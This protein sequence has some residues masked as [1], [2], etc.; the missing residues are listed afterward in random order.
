MTLCLQTASVFNTNRVSW[1]PVRPSEQ[2][3]QDTDKMLIRVSSVLE[4]SVNCLLLSSDNIACFNNDVCP[5]QSRLVER[6][7]GRGRCVEQH[8]A[9]CPGRDPR[10]I[11]LPGKRPLLGDSAERREHGGHLARPR[12]SG[13]EVPVY[14]PPLEPHKHD[15]ISEL[16]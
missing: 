3:L 15:Q 8:A 13:V 14:L 12:N 7:C 6:S 4:T 5:V 1:A 11:R 9:V 16:S 10:Q 2:R